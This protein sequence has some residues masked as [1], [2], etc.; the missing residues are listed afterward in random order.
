MDIENNREFS[1]L[2]SLEILDLTDGLDII[3]GEILN[4]INKYID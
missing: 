4:N 2:I 1:L 3:K